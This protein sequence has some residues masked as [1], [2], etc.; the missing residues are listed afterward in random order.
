MKLKLG[1]RGNRENA[2]KEEKLRIS[3]ETLAGYL[4]L[5]KWTVPE[6]HVEV[7]T[8]PLKAPFSYASVVQ[9]EDTGVYLY[10]VDE[11]SLAKEENELFFRMKNI[12]EYELQ[13]PEGEQTLSESFHAQMPRIVDSRPKV[14][15]NVSPISLRKIS[16]YLERDIV[17]YGKIDPLMFDPYVEDISCSGIDKSIFLWHRRYE[18]IRTNIS[19]KEEQDLNDLQALLESGRVARFAYADTLRRERER[20]PEVLDTW[21]AWWRDVLLVAEGSN[22]SLTNEDRR[23]VLVNHAEAIGPQGARHALE[24]TRRTT[25][26]LSKNAN[27]RLSLE[28]LLLDLPIL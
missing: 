20:I 14:F 13:A 15:K 1:K 3:E 22:A 16:Y 24:A 12:L 19:F 11:L 23:E 6:G 21:Q 18:N 9:N 27:V 28:V 17:G 8:Y 10:V 5:K 26:E 7:E 25:H 2:E 4:N